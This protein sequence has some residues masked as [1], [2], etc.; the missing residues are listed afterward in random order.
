V[1]LTL[2]PGANTHITDGQRNGEDGGEGGVEGEEGAQGQG[3]IAENVEEYEDRDPSVTPAILR[4][5]SIDSTWQ[6]LQST[7]VT[8][9]DEAARR[10][11]WMENA[12][13]LVQV[14]RAAYD[15]RVSNRPFSPLSLFPQWAS[16]YLTHI[17][18]THTT[19]LPSTQVSSLHRQGR[20]SACVKGKM[21]TAIAQGMGREVRRLLE[22]VQQQPSRHRD[23]VDREDSLFSSYKCPLTDDLLYEPVRTCC[24]GPVGA[25]TPAF[26]LFFF[27]VGHFLSSFFD[28]P[29]PPPPTS[30]RAHHPPHTTLFPGR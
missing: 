1:V 11:A 10:R 27:V 20:L 13:L 22:V 14:R 21:K 6:L 8:A 12:V 16:I 5:L 2:S 7:N 25:P 24:G 15:L 26:L 19:S 30:R 9:G 4:R 3:L 29:P 18:H 17:Q 28:R 23:S